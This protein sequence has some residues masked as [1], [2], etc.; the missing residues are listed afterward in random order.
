M[1]AR[2]D[3]VEVLLVRWSAIRHGTTV[4]KG[5]ERRRAPSLDQALERCDDSSLCWLLRDPSRGC[6]VL[7]RCNGGV[8]ARGFEYFAPSSPIPRVCAGGVGCNGASC[9]CGFWVERP[10]RS[11][12]R[13]P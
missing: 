1:N 8:E 3:G 12:G 9:V 11:L 6:V 2:R 10:A 5:G 4:A 13:S 7:H